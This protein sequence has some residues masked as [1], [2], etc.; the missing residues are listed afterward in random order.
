MPEKLK[1]MVI[2]DEPIVGKRLK[3]ALEKSGYEVEVYETGAGALKR[4]EEKDFDIVVTD[5]RMDEIDGMDILA[6][7]TAKAPRTKVIIITGYATIELAREA[8]VKGA[9]DFIAKP[10]KPDDLR[11]IIQKAAFALKEE[12]E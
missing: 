1:V 4:I 9:F 5:V 2:D 6:R 7:V 10:F 8:L 11:E 3:P 12:Q